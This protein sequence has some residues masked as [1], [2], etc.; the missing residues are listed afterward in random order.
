MNQSPA[1]GKDP[2]GETPGAPKPA[3]RPDLQAAPD[4]RQQPSGAGAVRISVAEYEE[5]K[6]LSA[7]R[8]DY[9]QRLRRAVADYLN[10]QKRIEKMKE[11]AYR[12]A[13]RRTTRRVL[14]LADGLARAI[15][16]AEKRGRELL[17]RIRE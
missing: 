6:T 14:P 3:A 7:E 1:H 13:L 5:L 15:E 17:Y 9:L 12:D 8:D 11:D 4:I 16:V 10:L 2:E